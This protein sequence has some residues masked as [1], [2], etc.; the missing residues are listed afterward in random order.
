MPITLYINLPNIMFAIESITLFYIPPR[1]S[2]LTDKKINL[3][4]LYNDILDIIL[5]QLYKTYLFENYT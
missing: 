4:K 5:I 2:S 1:L 3:N